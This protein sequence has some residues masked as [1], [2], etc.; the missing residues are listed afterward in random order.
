MEAESRRARKKKHKEEAEG[1]Y[2]D[3]LDVEMNL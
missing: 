1:M 2:Y 3:N